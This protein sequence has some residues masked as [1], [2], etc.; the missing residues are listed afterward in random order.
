MHREVPVGG[1][2]EPQGCD[3]SGKG[4]ETLHTDCMTSSDNVTILNHIGTNRSIQV[5]ELP[6]RYNSPGGISQF[7]VQRFWITNIKKKYP[8]GH[9][10][11]IP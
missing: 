1:N 7:D 4:G 11:S 8:P 5:D 3:G 10:T 9:F 2:S 6:A